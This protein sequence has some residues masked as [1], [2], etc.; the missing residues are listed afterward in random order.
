[1]KLEIELLDRGDAEGRPW[2]GWIVRL[3]DRYADGLCWDEM[4]GTVAA[5]TMKPGEPHPFQ[6]RLMTQAEWDARDARWAK[7]AEEIKNDADVIDAS[8]VV[9]S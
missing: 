4:L 3:G 8:F 9:E 5:L 2:T 7:R 1:M 6:G